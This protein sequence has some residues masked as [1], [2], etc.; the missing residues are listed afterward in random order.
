M[1][2]VPSAKAVALPQHVQ[3]G[4]ATVQGSETVERRWMKLT[5]SKDL[6]RYEMFIAGK[7]FQEISDIRDHRDLASSMRPL[8]ASLRWFI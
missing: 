5:G 8:E 2:G 3:G 6:L 1:P 7:S 4:E